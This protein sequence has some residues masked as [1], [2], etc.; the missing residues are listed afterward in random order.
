MYK[1]LGVGNDDGSWSNFLQCVC[2]IVSSVS[3]SSI[4]NSI[5]MFYIQFFNQEKGNV[6][7]SNFFYK[8]SNSKKDKYS[9]KEV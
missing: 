5:L 8:I 3:S 1:L 6:N 2:P 4:N 9:K 7:G